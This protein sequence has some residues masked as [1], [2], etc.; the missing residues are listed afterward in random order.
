MNKIPQYEPVYGKEE[1][2]SLIELINSDSWFSDHVKCREFE[3]EIKKVTGNKYCSLVSN[4]TIAISLALLASGVSAGDDV[5]VPNLSMIA[6][7]TAVSFIG[8]NPLFCDVDD[9]GCLNVDRAISMVN[10]NVKAIIY[11]TFNGRIDEVQIKKLMEFC[12]ER[13]IILLKDDA[14]SLG[15][16]TLDNLS[17]QHELYGDVHT[18]S[19]SPHKIVSSGQGG[20]I[21]TDNEE[22]GN[23]IKRIRDFGRLAGGEDVHDHFGINSKFTELQAVLGIGQIKKISERVVFKQK[24]YDHYFDILS[25]SNCVSIL[26]RHK[27][28]T[29]WFVD[30]YTDKRNELMEFL[31][32]KGVGTRKM[33]PTMHNQKCY[34]L[35]HLDGDFEK[36]FEIASRGLWLPSSFNLKEEQVI[37]I[38]DQIKEFFK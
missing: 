19:F 30:I 24:I 6:T 23:N 28:S 5:I 21:L 35:S 37:Y 4:G 16:R 8:A 1:K 9:R 17:I 32:Q 25:K 13:K 11:V 7:A 18:L 33:Y 29:P 20:A 26:P 10:S 36:T 31:K 3:E 34:G 2:A 22:L 27:N 14:Q 15:S 12:D 38:C